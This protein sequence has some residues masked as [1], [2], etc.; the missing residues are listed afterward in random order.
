MKTLSLNNNGD[1][2]IEINSQGKRQMEFVLVYPDGTQK[3][4]RADYY[5]AFWNFWG[6]SFRVK[7]QRINALAENYKLDFSGRVNLYVVHLAK[8]R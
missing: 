7:N 2:W 6:L 8:W 1:K 4:R 3:L 5:F